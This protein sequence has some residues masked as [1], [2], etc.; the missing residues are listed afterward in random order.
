MKHTWHLVSAAVALGGMLAVSQP[1]A[2]R[3]GEAAPAAAP[4][5]RILTV[6]GSVE[7]SP[8]G[9]TNW[10]AAQRD[11][12]LREGDRLRTGSA[13]RSALRH[14]GLGTRYVGPNSELIVSP[15][16]AGSRWPVLEY[17][18]GRSYIFNRDRGTRIDLRNRI[19]SAGSIGTEFH[20]EVGD[21][22]R[23]EVA[24]LEG[25][26][27][28]RNAQGALRLYTGEQGVAEA[29]AVPRRLAALGPAGRLKRIQWCLHYPVVLVTTD[30]KL[31]AAERTSLADSLA[32]FEH[33]DYARARLE[34][35]R[36]QAVDSEAVR[37]Y[38]AALLLGVG[39]VT[40]AEGL[41]ATAT[42]HVEVANALRQLVAAVQ[43]QPWTTNAG[44]NT[45]TA[46]L[47][48]SY[49]QQSRS[50]PDGPSFL[51][52]ARR[53]A[54]RATELAP[55]SAT[56]W[57]RLGELE[58][59][60]GQT[61]LAHQA[62]ERA[63][64]LAPGH[65]AALTLEGYVLAA[66]NRLGAARD[67]FEQVLASDGS[68]A[69]AWLGRGL[70]RIRQGETSAGR[71][72]L[73]VAAGLEPQRSVLR[74]YLGKA[75]SE[76]GD[77]QRA[78]EE[79]T[80]AAVLDPQ[81][82]TSPLYSA[83]E[84]QGRNRVNEAIADL[85]RSKELNDHR[86]L[87][88]SE[89]LL[90][91]DR[92]VRSANLAR[93]YQDAGMDDVSYR[94]AV[95]AVNSDYANYSAHLFL[96]NSY[97]ALRDPRLISLRYETPANTEY[98]LA[99]LLAPVGAGVLSPAVSQ[100]EYSKL[101]QRDR[102]GFTGTAEYWS[103]GDWVASGSQFGVFGGSSYA[104]DGQYRSED[105]EWSNGDVE[106]WQ[107]SARIKQQ[108][109]PADSV[110]LQSSFLDAEAG[111][112]SQRYDPDNHS[113]TFRSKE[114]QEP[115]LGVGYQHEWSPSA[116]TLFLAGWV[117]DRLSFDVGNQ[118]W[119][120]LAAVALPDGW[121][122]DQ[123][124]MDQEYQR[125]LDV[126]SVEAQQI[127]RAHADHQTILGAR[128]QWGELDLASAQQNP[129]NYQGFFPDPGDPDPWVRQQ[130]SVSL[131]DLSVYGYHTW[132]VLPSLAVQGGLAYQHVELPRNYLYAPLSSGEES[133][134]LLAPKGG[135]TWTPFNDTVVR[136]AYTSAL[137][138]VSLEQSYRLEPVQVAGFTQG[139]RSVIPEPET[140]G[141]SPAAFVETYGVS[142]EHK[143][144]T[145]TYLGL[146]GDILNSDVERCRGVF[147]LSNGAPEPAV[148]PEWLAYTE[149]ALT[150]TLN[151]LLGDQ[152]ALGARYRLTHSELDTRHPGVVIPDLPPEFL[153]DLDPLSPEAEVESWLHQVSLDA[154]FNHS[155][156]GFAR[157]N[158]LW[159]QQS[160]LAYS[161]DRPGD[162]FWQLNAFVGYRLPKRRAEL[163]LGVLNLGDQDYQL[164]P[165]NPYWEL[166]RERTL[167]V[168]LVVNL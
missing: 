74:S 36:V 115:L 95:R 9:G 106:Y 163:T 135:L 155:S 59:S 63:L 94:E 27:E 116:R 139:Y 2:A 111:D 128:M 132:Q 58:F 12:V 4:E 55:Q 154:V 105:G 39:E 32:A 84:L 75:F 112:V 51:E 114:R 108:L 48:E 33:G 127:F 79:Y 49:H 165:L 11:G 157:L 67:R 97:E 162:D 149:Q 62:L 30:L 66:E 145:R 77:A 148:R 109:G 110:Y 56:P 21:D 41:L 126:Y 96:A 89:L 53:A 76:T 54:V 133:Q 26:V 28:L 14:P 65:P 161:P 60:H 29:G 52:A 16:E 46:W 147:D 93:I 57:A 1:A 153:E 137:T 117:R 160:N 35:S 7:V 86:S 98:L 167:V 143:F 23:M 158:A 18:R 142:V 78:L 45:A 99:N 68:R 166:P 104:I 138:G 31:S 150:A 151:Q 25:E 103:R 17:L 37:V 38:H 3:G 44:A 80:L 144:R 5:L 50:G 113:R 81:D 159:F 168:R 129:S 125:D 124:G 91:Q 156:G 20:V 164:N 19:A 101:F 69:D 140:G 47:A 87:Y 122:V 13:S 120:G 107:V 88:R 102:F 43:F 119:P 130:S 70:C 131:V 6:E 141:P 90:D 71:D 146:G 34:L 10:V 123:F 92:A 42:D 83:L 100:Q 118:E 22:G 152:W 73:L 8:R 72:D 85:E 82:P 64:A 15:G 136:A 134:D 61:R 24:V 121:F 40:Q